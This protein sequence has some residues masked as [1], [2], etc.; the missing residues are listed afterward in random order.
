[1][2]FYFVLIVLAVTVVVIAYVLG[3]YLNRRASGPPQPRSWRVQ[4][5][6]ALG[7]PSPEKE[8]QALINWLLSQAFEQTGVKVADEPLAYQ[9][10][11]E[12]ARKAV[13]ELRTRDAITVSLPFL[14]A[15]ASGPKHFEVRVT[16]EVIQE[17]AR[18]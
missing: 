10:I 14:T 3:A 4:P 12:A 13:Q 8:T 5:P 9:R 15:D 11:V 16:R 7:Q 17:L 18:Y 1:M 2:N 6:R